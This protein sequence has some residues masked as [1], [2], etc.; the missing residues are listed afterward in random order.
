MI[1]ME[2]KPTL[3][4]LTRKRKKVEAYVAEKVKKMEM[5]RNA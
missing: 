2:T 4:I 3:P 5:A 1:K